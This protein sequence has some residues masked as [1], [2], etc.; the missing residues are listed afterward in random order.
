MTDI[1]NPNDKNNTDKF[2]RFVALNGG[3]FW[4]ATKSDGSRQ[5]SEGEILMIAQVDHV[6]D[7]PH[8]IHVRL[9]PSK[10]I[11]YGK[12]VRFLV[13]EFVNTFEFVDQAI[14]EAS[15]KADI[16]AIQARI[17]ADQTEMQ[18]AYTNTKLLDKLVEQD[19]PKE[20]GSDE[21]KLPV[22]LETFDADIVGAVKTQNLTSLMSKGLTETGVNQ[23]RSGLEEQKDIALRRSTWIEMRTK[24][25]TKMAGEMT[26]Y[27][28]EKAALPLAM[29][30]EMM[31]HVDDLMK[32]IGNLNLY[33]LKDVEIETIRQGASAAEDVKLS[34]TQRVLFMDEEMA[35][36]ADVSDEF[37]FRDHQRFLDTL[38]TS[39]E[40]VSQIF[41][42][43]RCIVSVAAT[44]QR[45]D[46]EG[47]SGREQERMHNENRRQFLLVRDGQNVHIV[48]SPDLFHNYSRT[49][50][51]TTGETEGVFR[52]FDG[53]NITYRDLDYTRKLK[54]H[55]RI[56]LGYK[57]L[58]IL[59]CGLDHN[60]SL[61]GKFYKGEAS[62]KFVSLEFQEKY[63]NFIHDVDGE[64]MLP[65]YRP[66][67][68]I[69]W[70]KKMN[71]EIS[72]GSRI[73]VQWERV[74]DTENCPAVFERPNSW[75]AGYEERR[76]IQYRPTEGEG[77]YGV[78]S[79]K[80]DD[81]VLK[82]EVSGDRLSD[83]KTRTFEATLN[84]SLALMTSRPFDILCVDRLNVKDAEWYLHDRPS[85]T[86]N[87]SGIRILKRAVKL[88][89]ELREEEKELRAQLDKSMDESGLFED[90]EALERIVD[91]AIAKWRC[92]HPR[93]AISSILE[94]T[95]SF[96][97]MC[98][99]IYFLAGK[100]RDVN[101]EI[102]VSEQKRG[103]D[104]VRLSLQPNGKYAVYSTPTSDEK[105]D[106]LE[107]F[108][109]LAKTTYNIQKKGVK[110]ISTSFVHLGKVN[111][112]ETV[113]YEKENI[114]DFT[115]TKLA[116]FTTP[117]KKKEYIDDVV[118]SNKS[119]LEIL[120]IKS[121]NDKDAIVRMIEEYDEYRD[122]LTFGGARPKKYVAEPA[123]DLAIAATTLNNT[124]VMIGLRESVID[125]LVW[126]VGDDKALQ[127]TLLS[128][129]E[130]AYGDKESA[131]SNFLSKC[132]RFKEV[133]LF[134]IF[135]VTYGEEFSVGMNEDSNSRHA[136][137]VSK[138]DGFNYSLSKQINAFS[139]KGNNAYVPNVSLEEMDEY[140]GREKPED[141]NPLI[142]IQNRSSFSETKIDVI[143]FSQDAVDSL[144]RVGF[145]VVDNFEALKKDHQYSR[146]TSSKGN[147][148]YY[149]VTME[150]VEVKPRVAFG[151]TADMSFDYVEVSRVPEKR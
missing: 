50:F 12:T 116:S 40:L 28:E 137:R 126:L 71:E 19:M 70:V 92:A 52:G 78:I 43:E 76:R 77:I 139:G 104:V 42:T 54:E 97:M 32:G 26:P 99:Q 66:E 41:P 10:C 74:F 30:K 1:I 34:V 150:W 53:Q 111:N 93:K 108:T 115:G 128:H 3:E 35:V 83:Y 113:V 135:D 37:D 89:S 84:V 58:L 63:F 18:Q 15:R 17:Q 106:R 136:P 2:E 62:L 141:Y 57:R 98:D 130:S 144:G 151:I 117:K 107:P 20:K 105:D 101:S 129:F 86:L 56:A 79:K 90:K 68:A 80:G 118:E 114:E 119:L 85:R 123:I 61:F 33:V 23:I 134:D 112:A 47:Y 22:K 29:S 143:K 73:L 91:Q 46:Y 100:G 51:P 133:N 45:H 64:G 146:Y 132:E 16:E 44:Q 5:V 31:D 124:P 131:K 142:V 21:A 149:K 65:S 103:R 39:D 140:Y 59:L 96:N 87:V 13:D 120:R 125:I 55:D 72:F 88:A 36:W 7:A 9:H 145:K 102:F 11:G 121:E 49:T 8:T 94:E 138:V 127:N 69:D 110:A 109:W 81:M 14:A 67:S 148:E 48:L 25:L 60:K 6:D 122:D 75:N 147:D 27:F 38:A 4:Q 24:R 95:K 82:V